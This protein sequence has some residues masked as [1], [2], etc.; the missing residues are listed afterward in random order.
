MPF[1]PKS[2][3]L[4]LRFIIDG[5]LINTVHCAGQDYLY[6]QKSIDLFIHNVIGGRCVAILWNL[7]K[8]EEVR[9]VTKTRRTK[10]E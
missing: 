9:R 4:E 8:Q 5:K 1:Y 6:I 10:N 2:E 3:D 7:K